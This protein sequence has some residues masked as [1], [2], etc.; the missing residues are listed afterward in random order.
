MCIG[1]SMSLDGSRGNGQLY[2]KFEH[3]K[4]YRQIQLHFWEAVTSLNPDNIV[5][6]D[7]FN[8][9]CSWF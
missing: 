4:E 8:L 2:F 3:N 1:L 5:V 7:I 6:G 9:L